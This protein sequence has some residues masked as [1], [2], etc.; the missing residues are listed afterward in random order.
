MGKMMLKSFPEDMSALTVDPCDLGRTLIDGCYKQTVEVQGRSREFFTY[1]PEGTESCRPCLVVAPPSGEDGLEYMERSGLKAFADEKKMF[2][3]L[4]IPEDGGW[5]LS[6]ADADFMNA[7]YVEAQA[8]DYYVTMQDNFYACGIGDGADV[9]QQAACRMSSEWSGLMTMGDLK[10]D[11]GEIT[12]N[13]EAAGMGANGELQ[14]AAER[15]QL[16][17]WMVVSRWE[18]AS[19]SAASYWR[20]NNHSGEEV[21]STKDADYVWF[22]V[23]LRQNLEMDEEMI[24][25]VRVTVGDTECSL[26]RL[27]QMWSYIGLARRHR[28]Q[29]RKNLRYFKDPVLCGAERKTMELDGLTREWYEYVPEC[30]TPDKTWPVVVVMHGRGGTAETFFDISNMYQVANR[31][32][33]IVACPQAGVYQQKKGGLRNVASWSGTLNGKPIDDI[34]FIRAMLE[35]M[36]SRLPVDKGRIYACGQSSGGMMADTL[37]EFSGELFAATVSWSGLYTPARSTVRGE[38]S[39]DAP[40]SA[41]MFG[42]KDR[43]TAGS[44]QIPGVP[45]TISETFKD[46]IE[47]KFRRYGLDKSA[48]QIWK[49]DPITWYSYPNSQGV[50]MFTV[51]IVDKMVHA[52]YPEESWISYDQFF[53]NFMRDEDGTVC[54]RGKRV[55]K[56]E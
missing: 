14:I 38:R 4:M 44:A 1:I 47:E 52:N 9:A 21:F 26:S 6:G 28:G 20:A 15:A 11:L 31:R 40:P 43:L 54:Y 35:N 37:C 53:C 41:M 3:F 12:L 48:V 42:E 50:P 39:H 33:F 17:V 55:Q 46:M 10:T 51:G 29:E 7:V 22:P 36:E 30:C 8:R 34:G 2:L 27:E 16:P 25:Q 24:A 18:G 13:K 32:K 45:F 56:T 5:D 49:D 23:L 19:V